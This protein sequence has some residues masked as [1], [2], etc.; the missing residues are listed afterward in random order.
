M[1]SIQT[2]FVNTEANF[3]LGG[4]DQLNRFK[5]DL[6]VEPI[7][8]EDDERVRISVPQ[9]QL[10]KN[11]NDINS[12]NNAFRLYIN[13]ATDFTATDE[14]FILGNF[15]PASLKQLAT[16]FE[17]VF[18]ARLNA[19][20]T[21]GGGSITKS[22]SST[23]DRS[24]TCGDINNDGLRLPQTTA[25][26]GTLKI[27]FTLAMP[28]GGGIF[29]GTILVQCLQLPPSQQALALAGTLST[30]TNDQLFNDSYILFGGRRVETYENPATSDSFRQIISG[31]GNTF[32][33]ISWFNMNNHPYTLPYV[34]L[35][36]DNVRN[37]ATQNM[38]D[39]E[40]EHNHALTYSTVIAKIP[41]FTDNC[42]MSEF[43]MDNNSNFFTLTSDRH[44]TSMIFSV[45][46]HRGRDLP[47]F[48]S[49]IADQR[50]NQVGNG[51]CNFT[52]NVE[53]VKIPFNPRRLD[54]G[55]RKIPP[56]PRPNLGYGLP[57]P[58][59]PFNL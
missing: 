45:C 43:R 16:K 37:Q 7:N 44:I 6:N 12:T 30:A 41:R 20:Y 36:L 18:L 9:F 19:K 29:D 27:D 40:E 47:M 34:Y 38:I 33:F 54:T 11:W 2:L 52:L 1:S 23:P 31:T 32:R 49:D 57:N 13:G 59:S 25:N 17:E 15:E 39:S 14:I 21:G 51:F 53:K 55:E 42:Q 26:L 48:G 28:L 4:G 50:Q 58:T 5:V 10:E 35:R 56:P 22:V 24:F 46:D 3:G 8:C